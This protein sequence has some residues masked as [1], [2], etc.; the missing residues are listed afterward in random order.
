MTKEE[1]VKSLRH[2]SAFYDM[3]FPSISEACFMPMHLHNLATIMWVREY[4]DDIHAK[5]I[6]EQINCLW[7]K[8]MLEFEDENPKMQLMGK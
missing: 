6:R 1:L 3:Y 5:R 4:P 8:G 2:V 7:T